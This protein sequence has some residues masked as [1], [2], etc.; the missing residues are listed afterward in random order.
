MNKL[1][2]Y[3]PSKPSTSQS[4][5]CELD[6]EFS[7]PSKHS[8]PSSDR[9][10][11]KINIETENPL[12]ISQFDIEKSG[13]LF[14]KRTPPKKL[15][16]KRKRNKK[17]KFIYMNKG[18]APDGSPLKNSLSGYL[19]NYHKEGHLLLNFLFL[20]IVVPLFLFTLLMCSLI[21]LQDY[22]DDFCFYPV[23]CVCQSIFVYLYSIFRELLQFDSF[24]IAW[25]YFFS[26][27]LTND[28]FHKKYLKFVYFSIEITG[29]I[30]FYVI[31][32]GKKHEFLLADLR[33]IRG[34]MI[35]AITLCFIIASTI[36]YK[37]FSRLFLKNLTK[38]GFFTGYYFF[39]AL[40]LKNTFSYY[41]LDKFSINMDHDLAVNIFKIFLLIYYIFYHKITKYYVLSFYTDILKE[42]V[43]ISINIVIAAIKFIYVD[44]LS[45]KVLNILTIPL[46]EVYSWI[47]FI[48]YFYSLISVYF[49][50]S[51]WKTLYVKFYNK[52][53]LKK[54]PFPSKKSL[55]CQQYEKLE[56]GCILEANI[57][58]FIR[59]LICR[60]YNYFFY[61]TKFK[62]LFA[63]CSLKE[64]SEY[65]SFNFD[66]INMIVIFSS[67]FALILF[68][69]IFMLKKKKIILNIIVEDFSMVIRS[70]FFIMYFTQVDVS[71]QYYM[72]LQNAQ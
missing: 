64:S 29:L 1:F 52:F 54:L 68:I 65:M 22:I 35:F 24:L 70:I 48:Y 47:S 49:S 43:E 15:S 11:E 61:I 28:F 18:I 51:L 44:A 26:G 32:Y 63:N 38:I 16:L 55:E 42:N 58:I 13:K 56:S 67:H 62:S 39:H 72:L 34:G 20:K 46:S 50:V 19:S 37:E 41:L 3:K 17:G 59:I 45:I 69:L 23:L 71:I 57:L 9:Q 21:L 5:R 30:V 14:L 27:Y 60:Y 36:F 12:K 33:L 53:N 2:F 7:L 4:A 6:F 40:Y 8:N 66:L 25:F 31:F 10:S